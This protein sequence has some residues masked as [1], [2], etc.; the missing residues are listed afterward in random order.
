MLLNTS[1]FRCLICEFHE[2]DISKT[3]WRCNNCGH[4]YGVE[5]GIPILV[6]DQE[7]HHREL[8][9]ARTVNPNWYVGEQA[10]EV[11]SPWRHHLKKR[12]L[13]VESVITNYLEAKGKTS[14]TTLLDLG[15]GDGNHLQYLQKYAQMVF[16]SDYNLVRL[17]RAQAQQP[18]STLFLADILDYPALDNFFEIIFFNHVIEHIPEDSQALET[19]YRILKPGGLLVLGTPNEGVWWWQLAYRLQPKTL[20]TT[21]HVHFYTAETLGQKVAHCGFDLLETKHMGWGPPHWGV[22]GRIRKYKLVDDFFEMAGQRFFPSQ[23]SSLYVI[24]TKTDHA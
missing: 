7:L 4:E 22:D 2:V 15:C 20:E 23:A 8:E 12:R 13:Y 24:A 19:I 5:Q 14:A 6:R 11:A 10:P 16:G 3:T 9:Q 21:D 17:V 18:K 1:F